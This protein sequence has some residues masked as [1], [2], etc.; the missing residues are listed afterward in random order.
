M[1]A[2]P[3][4]ARRDAWDI[5]AYVQVRDSAGQ[6]VHS[7]AGNGYLD[8]LRTS[9]MNKDETKT[10]LRALSPFA[11]VWFCKACQQIADSGEFDDEPLLRSE[12]VRSGL[13]QN[14]KIHEDEH[15]HVD[16][17]V[18]QVVFERYGATR[19]ETASLHP[20]VVAL[21]QAMQFKLDKNERKPCLELNPSGEKRTWE[22]C[23]TSW[24]IKR[25]RMELDELEQELERGDIDEARLECADVANFMMMV[26]DN[27][28]KLPERVQA[29]GAS[30]PAPTARSK[31]LPPVHDPR[32][33]NGVVLKEPGSE[34]TPD[35]S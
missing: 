22:Q 30:M 35:N 31:A 15:M 34:K 23:E 18:M 1:N 8:K 12:V 2:R 21:A 4:R 28:G 20:A 29:L 33:P 32:D 9:D 19:L 26:H 25:A 11:R 7:D 24:L 5:P 13:A 6:L 14:L 3:R 27:L 16:P 17:G 10:K